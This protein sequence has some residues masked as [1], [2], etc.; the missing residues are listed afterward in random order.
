[1]QD[2]IVLHGTT[3]VVTPMGNPNLRP[4]HLGFVI[5]IENIKM[6]KSG[7]ELPRSSNIWLH[8]LQFDLFLFGIEQIE[9]YWL[10][11]V[12]IRKIWMGTLE[13]EKLDRKA[14]QYIIF[15]GFAKLALGVRTS[16]I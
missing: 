12:K 4:W 16:G 14:W 7:W 2:P 9:H 5:A 1:M 11:I 10:E 3:K 8:I 15:P 13:I 6:K